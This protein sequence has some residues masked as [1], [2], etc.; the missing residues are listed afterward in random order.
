M[1]IDIAAIMDALRHM[2]IEEDA[3]IAEP[4]ILNFHKEVIKSIERYGR[5]HKLEIMMRYKLRTRR[6]FED[7]DVGLRMLGKRKLNLRPSRVKEIGEMA[8]LF[9]GVKEGG[10][11]D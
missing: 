4:D 2:A 9:T 8:G 1:A 6:W 10:E 7:M 5:T 11:N 3:K